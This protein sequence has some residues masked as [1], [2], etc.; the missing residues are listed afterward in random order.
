MI[1]DQEMFMT[2]WA[3]KTQLYIT[4]SIFEMHPILKNHI[5]TTLQNTYSYNVDV[6]GEATIH[7]RHV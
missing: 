4:N 3:D 5:W 2:M 7:D 1:G 6:I